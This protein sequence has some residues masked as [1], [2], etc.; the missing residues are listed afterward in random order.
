MP[1][2][3]L[4]G[5]IRQLLTMRGLEAK[6]PLQDSQLEIITEAGIFLK[7]EKIHEIGSYWD[8]YPEAQSIGAKMETLQGDFVALPG[9][10]DCH[11]HICFAGSRAKDFAM[12]NTGK[13]YLEIANSGG[14]IWDTV[15]QT[16]KA[17]LEQLVKLTVKRANRHLTDGVTTI[18]VKSGYGLSVPEEIKMLQA[19][20]QA[21]SET[22]ADLVPTCLAAHIC[23]KDFEGSAKEYLEI[24]SNELFPIL[25]SENL[26]N[27]IDAFIEDS[28]FSS[29]D[30]WEYLQKAKDFGFDI[31]VH[32]DQFHVG[33]S[34]VAVA[35]GT[36]SADHL[37]AST[38]KEI[39]LLANSDTV[40]VALPGA[41]IGLG[42][43]FTPARKLLDSGASLAIA[44][45]W[46]PG[47]APMG[48][49]LMQ[50]SILGTFEKLSNAEVLAGITC[51]AAAALGLSDRGSVAVGKLADI[52][53]FQTSDYREIT[54]HQGKL[55]PKMVFKRGIK[56]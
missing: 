27:R 41:S 18:E 37:E 39:A 43:A 49:L 26:S 53:L 44:S 23:P 38:E 29:E 36:I 33:G 54:Y 6:G 12:R 28:A 21:N 5:P 4:I 11:T 48:D 35:F 10:V 40:A 31:T 2:Y 34:A 16:R 24:I 22:A 13:S 17:A 20:K 46:N 1:I 45:D 55:K 3:T 19:I 47:S 52:L 42:M 32:A 25:K 50:A 7:D 9:F 8:I 30:I 51:R 56:I 15:T 14:G